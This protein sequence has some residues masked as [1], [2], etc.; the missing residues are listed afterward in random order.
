MAPD[1][2]LPLCARP[3]PDTR[4]KPAPRRM[5]APRRAAATKNPAR[6][7]VLAGQSDDYLA[8]LRLPLPDARSPWAR[9]F[10]LLALAPLPPA[11]ARAVLPL[12]AWPRLPRLPALP[13]LRLP[14]EEDF[15]DAIAVSLEPAAAPRGNRAATVGRSPTCL[16]GAREARL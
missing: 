8:L 5:P 10:W 6:V 11:L 13:L 2:R 7:R 16:V 9:P 15:E 1:C 3:H 4:R 14:P 12:F